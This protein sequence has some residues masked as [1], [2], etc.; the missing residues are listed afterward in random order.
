MKKTMLG[1]FCTMCL[2]LVAALTMGM[3]TVSFAATPDAKD[4]MKVHN[5]EAGATVT[6]YQIV[7]EVKGEWKPVDGVTIADP[8]NP[9]AAEI[10]AIAKNPPTA[11]TF[12]LTKGADGVYSATGKAAGM[13]LILV[14]NTN[15]TLYN[16]MVVSVDYDGVE[17]SVDANTNFTND[18][19]AKSSTPKVTKKN[20]QAGNTATGTTNK[21]TS[22]NIGDKVPFTIETTIPSYS[23]QYNK[24]EFTVSDAMSKGL[25][26]PT[27]AKDVTVKVGGIAVDATKYEFKA[28][29]N[30]FEVAFKSDYIKSLASKTPAERKVVITYNGTL[31]ANAEWNFSQ[32]K[33][34]ATIKFTNNP[35]GST[36]T[37]KD[38]SKIYTFGL[39]ANLMGSETTKN[40]KTHEVIKLDEKGVAQQLSYKED[41]SEETVTNALS[42]A[43]FGLY[44]DKECTNEVKK[45]TTSQNGYMEMKGLKEGTYY[46]KE[47]S[48]PS[49]YVPSS[50]ISKVE[51][52]AVYKD[53]GLLNNYT[54]TI[55]D[56][57]GNTYNSTYTA[58]YDAGTITNVDIQSETLF[59][60]NSRM[61][62]LPSTG[63]MGTYI[64]M[65]VGATLMAFAVM[66]YTK[67]AKKA[68]ETK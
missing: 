24:V 68:N 11:N 43:V 28:V 16:P 40:K 57:K 65:I 27:E 22:Y 4:V 10:A 9:T 58:A 61:P 6:A 49:G 19:Y 44:S 55:T 33:N 37:H 15:A 1:R 14:T 45:A 20:D 8:T 66:A 53:N 36:G 35:N 31:N 62:G 21:G 56:A 7:K 2:A 23:D 51:I 39:D 59:I 30:G 41:A 5:V 18:A 17:D 64:F 13:Y 34:E 32:N 48:A 54:V 63:G 25:T 3:S 50:D 38:D 52:K 42:G 60:K 12:A 29:G 26:A 46:L 67:N 47:I